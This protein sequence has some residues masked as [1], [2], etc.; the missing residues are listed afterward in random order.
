M[1]GSVH[2]LNSLVFGDVL[3]VKA[4]TL[5]MIQ[6]FEI[7]LKMIRAQISYCGVCKIYE[8]VAVLTTSTSLKLDGQPRLEANFQ[9][10]NRLTSSA[11]QKTVVFKSVSDV[12]EAREFLNVWVKSV[13]DSV[14]K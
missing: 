8:P 10:Y 1:G 4:L 14:P 7:K 2:T 13:V 6:E 12:V 11:H 3:R 9:L 5:L